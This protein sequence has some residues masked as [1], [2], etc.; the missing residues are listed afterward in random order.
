MLPYLTLYSR[1]VSHYRS[2]QHWAVIGSTRAHSRCNQD[3]K[4][5]AKAFANHNK[6]DGVTL[7]S[8]LSCTVYAPLWNEH[9]TE[10]G[11]NKKYRLPAF[12]VADDRRIVGGNVDSSPVDLLV[13]LQCFIVVFNMHHVLVDA[14]K[15]RLRTYLVCSPNMNPANTMKHMVT[16]FQTNKI[17]W[18]FQ[19]CWPAIIVQPFHFKCGFLA[20]HFWQIT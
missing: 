1:W 14:V 13:C 10:L 3:H 9:R 5:L 11:Q 6:F 18:V 16:T 12:S 8:C 19:P 4:N 17:P 15:R 7:C 2:T 20:S